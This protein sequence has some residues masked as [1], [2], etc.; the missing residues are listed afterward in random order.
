MWE[1]ILKTRAGLLIAISLTLLA[2]KCEVEYTPEIAPIYWE[3]GARPQDFGADDPQSPIDPASLLIPEVGS[4]EE[5]IFF[6][7]I[8]G[9]GQGD[10]P[11]I[12]ELFNP[13]KR[14]DPLTGEITS[15]PT[16]G[17]EAAAES[18]YGSPQELAVIARDERN[19]PLNDWDEDPLASLTGD[20]RDEMAGQ[21]IGSFNRAHLAL[22]LKEIR[23]DPS[24]YWNVEPAWL[25]EKLAQNQEAL[26]RAQ[27]ALLSL[28][29]ADPD[30]WRY[31]QQAEPVGDTD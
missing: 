11:S 5:L 19:N 7:E 23:A 17:L 10:L 4:R 22:F 13:Y 30:A 6:A 31:I 18:F 14:E 16:A 29:A 15:E 25:T 26:L 24:L 8:L 2:H 9:F 3:P 20:A 27:F 28:Y 1:G 21:M 12:D